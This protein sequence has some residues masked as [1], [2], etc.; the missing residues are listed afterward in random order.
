MS[1]GRKS[2]SEKK[3]W[4][5]PP[6]YIST[7]NEFFGEIDLDPCSNEHS[8]VDAY[9][10]YV[11]PLT[12]G[13]IEKWNYKTIFVNPPYG[14]NKENKTS[15]YNWIE[16]GYNANLGGSELL[17]LIPVAT[18]TKHFKN[19]IFKFACGICFLNDTRLKFWSDGKEDKKGAPMSCC[20]VYF[21][22]D[23][24]KFENIF[25]KHGKCFRIKKQ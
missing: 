14:R 3:D 6:K 24:H 25:S 16:K 7:I 15:I 11:F 1:A 20:F 2:I 13:L 22:K 9:M 17:F 23:Y 4:N 21:G 12:D 5:T 18:N 8:M 10:E 19:I